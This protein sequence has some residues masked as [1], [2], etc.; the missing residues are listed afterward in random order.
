MIDHNIGHPDSGVHLL[1]KWRV[2]AEM[3]Q[4]YGAQSRL[5]EPS[6]MRAN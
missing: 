6:E 3:W 4:Q 5:R 1:E 2:W